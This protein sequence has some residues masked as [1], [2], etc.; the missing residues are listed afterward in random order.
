MK[1]RE[2]AGLPEE[3][4]CQFDQEKFSL[5]N[6]FKEC[7]RNSRRRS[8]LE[9]R[10]AEEEVKDVGRRRAAAAAKITAP[11]VAEGTK[12]IHR[13]RKSAGLVVTATDVTDGFITGARVS[14][15]CPIR[16]NT[17]AVLAVAKIDSNSVELE[18]S[19]TV[20]TLKR[21]VSSWK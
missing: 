8:A 4:C 18:S 11:N 2:K 6:S 14:K 17:G 5:Q 10:K 9:R 13:E 12:T 7:S 3:T 20:G 16:R 19:G 1:K 21:N 15:K